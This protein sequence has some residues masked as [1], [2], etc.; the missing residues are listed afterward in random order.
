M[1]CAVI[2]AQHVVKFLLYMPNKN[3]YVFT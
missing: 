1:F 2:S 3:E